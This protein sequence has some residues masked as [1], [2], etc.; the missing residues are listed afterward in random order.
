M[1]AAAPPLIPLC[2]F[3]LIDLA[4]AAFDDPPPGVADPTQRQNSP[5]E[6]FGDGKLRF[7]RASVALTPA[8]V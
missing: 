1:H 8:G 5:S 6:S 4:V 2:I 7:G 3:A